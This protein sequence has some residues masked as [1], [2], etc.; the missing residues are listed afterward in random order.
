MLQAAP[1]MRSART[2]A[3]QIT[4]ALAEQ[5]AT[6]VG[7]ASAGEIVSGPAEAPAVLLKR[8]EALQ[9]RI[10]SVDDEEQ[11]LSG[12]SGGVARVEYRRFRAAARCRPVGRRVPLVRGPRQKRW[13]R[14]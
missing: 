9:A 11:R 5:T 10:G 6:A 2:L 8:R 7:T 13:L 4:T 14:A 3:G 1:R 12:S